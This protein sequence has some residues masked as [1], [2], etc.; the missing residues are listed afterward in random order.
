MVLA[1]GRG[2]RMRPLTDSLPKPLVTVGGTALLDH[3]LDRLA[4]A[5][6]ARAVVNVWHLAEMI[7]GHLAERASP[8][9]EISREDTLLETGGG[10]VKALPRLGADPF[11]AVNGDVLW[12]DGEDN[13]LP[14]LAHAWDDGA[15]DALLLLQPMETAVGFDGAGDFFREPD[16]R[17]RRRGD[18]QRAPYAFMGVQ[19][20][21][22]RAFADAP[23]GAFS[24]NVIYDHA[25]ANRRLFGLVHAGEWLHVGT[26]DGLA[27][28]ERR[29]AEGSA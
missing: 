20:L 25:L 13:A 28:A 16:G 29:W 3:A 26:I 22:P 9:I 8:A 17:L 2:E 4:D 10:I 23:A 11:Y 12:R 15:M 21:H 5:N 6:V 1:A 18:A 19:I 24:L 27:E 7:V 14:R